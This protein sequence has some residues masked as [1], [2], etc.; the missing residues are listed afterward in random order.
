MEVEPSVREQLARAGLTESVSRTHI[1]LR[2][3]KVGESLYDAYAAAEEWTSQAT[4]MKTSP[5]VESG[6][7]EGMTD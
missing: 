3:D 2:T 6:D 7:D 1:F 5:K 4:D